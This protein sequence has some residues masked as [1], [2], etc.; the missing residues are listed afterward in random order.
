[1][2]LTYRRS[3]F[4][5]VELLVAMTIGIL[6]SSIVITLYVQIGRNFR[7]DERYAAM[8]E[9]G[10]FSLQMLSN[11]L[12]MVDFW[13]RIS[14]TDTISSTLTA[15]ANSCEDAISMFDPAS[16]VLYINYHA[17][18]PILQFTPCTA[19]TDVQQVNAGMLA[20]KRVSG[21]ETASVFVDEADSD[22]DGN[23]TEVIS[24]GVSSLTLGSVYLRANATSGSLINT[25]GPS[26]GPPTGQSDWE[27]TPVLYF[28]RA[29][30]DTVGDGVPALCRMSLTS[31]ATT[32][33]LP[34][35]I[36]EGIEDLHV[37][38]G[39]DT[40][41][42]GY[43]NLYLGEPTTAQIASAVTAQIFVLARPSSADP[44]YTNNKTYQL[45]DVTR[46][47]FNDGFFRRVYSTTVM[48]RNSVSRI[49]ID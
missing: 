16:P 47:P 9:N 38:F 44:F 8:Q 34:E 26:A 46:G 1:V 20:I 5:L 18:P 6:V 33:A 40:D 7:F 11:D 19:V 39:I 23:V 2:L 45:G 17:S 15:T 35:C 37:Q 42:D 21:I 30:Y 24:T 27:Y 29:Y 48:L 13:G 49:L 25:A 12:S 14:A 3:G 43:A 22:G 10:R 36:A 31:G 41:A 4:S 28:V 32:F